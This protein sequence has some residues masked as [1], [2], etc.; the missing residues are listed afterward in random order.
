MGLAMTLQ[1]CVEMT[2][3]MGLEMTLQICVG[4]T[5]QILCRND[6]SSARAEKK[7]KSFEGVQTKPSPLPSEKAEPTH[8]AS[9]TTQ[10]KQ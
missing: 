1:I 2:L 6:S 5:L 3:Q 9:A 4:T 7:I 10:L 8:N